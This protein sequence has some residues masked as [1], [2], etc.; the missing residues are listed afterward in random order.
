MGTTFEVHPAIGIAR[1]GT[2]VQHFVGPEPDEEPPSRYR[3]AAGELLRQAARFRVFECERDDNNALLAC[4]EVTRDLG[5]IEWTVHLAN[6]KAAGHKFF[7][8]DGPRTF[9]NP[10]D[11][12]DE[13]T[14]DPGPRT[15]HAENPAASFDTG[16]F[17]GRP[18]PLGEIRAEDSGRLLVLGGF[19]KAD[20]DPEGLEL[21]GNFADNDD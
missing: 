19:G 8:P 5:T 10:Q 13:L 9:R 20:S 7:P 4:R 12:R 18:V 11:P 15:V 21:S 6:T 17:R 3:D 2:S 1:V 16:T 14:I